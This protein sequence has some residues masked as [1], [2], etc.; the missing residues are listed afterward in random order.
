L[1]GEERTAS[2]SWE[3]LSKGERQL[4]LSTFFKRSASKM[5][6]FLPHDNMLVK[7][8]DLAGAKK[9]SDV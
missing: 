9:P 5:N 2:I 4:S 3:E 1:V 6:L 7:G 8:D